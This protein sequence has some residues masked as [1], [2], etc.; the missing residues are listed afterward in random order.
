[1][2]EFN[3]QLFSN[4][5]CGFNKDNCGEQIICSNFKFNF[6]VKAITS[7]CL[8]TYISLVLEAYLS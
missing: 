1:M 5:Y 7:Y 4:I 6:R 3:S 2:K 8:F